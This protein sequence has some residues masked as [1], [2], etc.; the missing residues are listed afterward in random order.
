MPDCDHLTVIVLPQL[1]CAFLL[2]AARPPCKALINCYG[3]FAIP[4]ARHSVT[5]VVCPSDTFVRCSETAN[6][7][8]NMQNKLLRF[9]LVQPF[10]K[11]YR[12]FMI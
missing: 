8:L 3:N 10:A 12:L 5:S 1:P 2:P 11:Y 7:G 6:L 4:S 9:Y